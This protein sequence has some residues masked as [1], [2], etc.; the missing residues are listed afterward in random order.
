[1]ITCSKLPSMHCQKKKQSTNDNQQII[2]IKLK[3]HLLTIHNLL[4]GMKIIGNIY[5][6]Y[7]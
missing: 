2:G 1:M 5:H 6:R 7:K 4:L 3:E